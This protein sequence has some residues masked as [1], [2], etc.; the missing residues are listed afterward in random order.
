VDVTVPD[1]ICVF[2]DDRND[3]NL[4]PF[5]H[6]GLKVSVIGLP[7]PAQWRTRRG[8]ELF[9]PKHFGFAIEYQ[10]IEETHS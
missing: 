2:D 9:G 8:L 3:P 10:P 6:E 4:N 7:A 1:L 5:F